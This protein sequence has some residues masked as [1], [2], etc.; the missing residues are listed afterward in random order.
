MEDLKQEDHQ[1]DPEK[2]AGEP[3][4]DQWEPEEVKHYGEL[5]LGTVPGQSQG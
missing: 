4:D 1:E 2:F 3:V 5:D